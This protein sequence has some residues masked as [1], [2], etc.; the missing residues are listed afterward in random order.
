MHQFIKF[1]ALI[2]NFPEILTLTAHEF[3]NEKI[4]VKP[5]FSDFTGQTTLDQWHSHR[6]SFIMF[7]SLQEKLRE[8]D[9]FKEI[10]TI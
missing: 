3:C 6:S 2:F 4:L 5:F 7:L 9:S 10:S 1:L 8:S